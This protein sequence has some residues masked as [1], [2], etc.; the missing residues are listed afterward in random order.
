MSQGVSFV[1][2]LH[3]PLGRV[4]ASLVPKQLQGKEEILSG[5][6]DEVLDTNLALSHSS[7]R[8]Q[9]GN[10]HL[11]FLTHNVAGPMVR[12]KEV[13]DLQSFR[14]GSLDSILSLQEVHEKD[15]D[16]LLKD[17][18]PNGSLVEHVDSNNPVGVFSNENLTLVWAKDFTLQEKDGRLFNFKGLE[19]AGK[20]YLLTVIPRRSGDLELGLAYKLKEK[21]GDSSLKPKLKIYESFIKVPLKEAILQQLFGCS[22][23]ENPALMTT[24]D[25]HNDSGHRVHRLKHVNMH[26]PAFGLGWERLLDFTKFLDRLVTKQFNKEG[27]QKNTVVLAGDM[28]N[29]FPGEDANLF[30]L[31]LKYGFETLFPFREGTYGKDKQGNSVYKHDV[32]AVSSPESQPWSV[33]EKYEVG[34]RDTA[35]DHRSVAATLALPKFIP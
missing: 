22:D 18:S 1:L 31:L 8:S 7:P 2:P 29:I 9:T 6:A 25:I 24:I 16:A 26:T 11:N 13:L 12:L 20:H 15:L 17:L 32:I 21:D 14:N 5:N 28:N 19:R 23:R 30:K 34:S 10:I 33:I 4:P 35:S 27:N 3:R